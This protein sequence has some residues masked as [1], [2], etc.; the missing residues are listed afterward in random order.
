VLRLFKASDQNSKKDQIQSRL[1]LLAALLIVI[2]ALILTLAPAVRLHTGISA[3]QFR[4]WVGV[5]VWGAIF[6]FLHD[7]TKKHLP[8]RDPYLLPIIAVLSGLGLMTIW[9]LYPNLGLR[10]TLW[11][12]LGGLILFLGVKYSKFLDY[13]HRYKYIWLILGLALTALTIIVGENPGGDGPRLWLKF[14]GVYFQPSEPLKLL[15]IAYLAGFFS[16]RLTLKR[17]SINYFFPIIVVTGIAILLL[18]FQRDLGTASIFLL[19]FLALLYSA[20]S[21]K[22]IAWLSPIIILIAAVVGYFF[23]DIV[24]TRID[25]WLNPFMDPSGASYQVI[26]SMIAIAEGGLMGSGPGL[27]SPGLVPVSVS[28]FIFAAIAEEL[29]FLGAAF[30]ILLIILIIYR[31]VKIASSS[32]RLF[33]R[34]L[35]LGVV[36][37]FGIQS[38]L[39]IGGNIGLLPLT[40]VTL[41]F[42][43]YGGSSLIVSFAAV[44][45]LLIISQR[46]SKLEPKPTG[47][48]QRY[49]L[50]SSCLI[51]ALMVEILT[52]SLIAFWFRSD[53]IAR[54]ENPRWVIEDRYVPRGDILDRDNRIIVQTI[55]KIGS[56]KRDSDHIPLYPI[57]GY[58]SGIYGQTGI[59]ATMF[60][61]LRGYEGYP[62]SDQF[63]KDLL[64]NQPA[65]G[66]DIRLTI[67]LDFQKTADELLDTQIGSVILMNA[68]TGEILAMAS[69]PYFDGANLEKEWDNLIRDENAPLINRATQGVYPAGSS[70][71]PFILTTQLD[72]TQNDT[73]PEDRF[74]NLSGDMLC[75]QQIDEE[76]TWKSLTI[77][78]CL[79][80]QVEL[81]ALTGVTSLLNLYED[82]GF[83]TAPELHLDVAEVEQVEITDED[84]LYKGEKGVDISPLQMVLAASALTNQGRLP[85]PRI[86]NGYRDPEGNWVTLPELGES[87]QALPNTLSEEVISLLKVPG[88]SYWGVT[89]WAKDE[90]G[91]RITWFIG[92][93]ST[94]WQGQP[95]AV[96]VVLEGDEPEIAE[97]IGITLIEKRLINISLGGN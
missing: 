92:G 13:L 66:L 68:E 19:I 25:T 45:I 14:V 83:Y 47:K 10:Q 2:Y 76:I 70:L 78:G 28:D 53:M 3:F 8:H 32:Q 97:N 59:E 37:Y 80:A 73:N 51:L 69:H 81:S 84:S 30:I 91:K 34:Y 55:G 88:S 85:A 61:Y 39:I 18:I 11:I 42:V 71:L 6:V 89:A 87:H 94:D 82:L 1:I 93:T 24:Q 65:E 90:D 52:S 58:T 72:L 54:P 86:V 31:G 38:I 96:A 23:I 41:P 62:F 56:Y 21:Q 79:S 9:R 4:H 35:S 57:V 49:I 33:H 26:Q 27:G 12:A 64:Y 20:P 15:L 95:I 67:D 74:S 29:G 75:T 16:D 77:N 36:F 17:Q 40:G 22:W 60:D 63:W 48:P 46:S 5:I 7:Q 50:V 43:S 44:V